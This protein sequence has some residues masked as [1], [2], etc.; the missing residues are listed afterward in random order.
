MTPPRTDLRYRL[1]AL[2]DWLRGN[3]WDRLSRRAFRRGVWRAYRELHGTSPRR[4]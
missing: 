4:M 3:R 2:W 1:R